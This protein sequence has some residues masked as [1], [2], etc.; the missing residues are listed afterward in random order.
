MW[1]SLRRIAAWASNTCSV[2][3]AMA[4]STIAGLAERPQWRVPGKTMHVRMAALNRR[5]ASSAARMTGLASGVRERAFSG[6]RA[7]RY[8]LAASLASNGTAMN[9]LRTLLG[10]Q[11]RRNGVPRNPSLTVLLTPVRI[12]RVFAR[13]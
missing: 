5:K 11:P 2:L 3:F 13:R 1:R 10:A 8:L 7:T 12:A 6:Y 9:T 4:Q